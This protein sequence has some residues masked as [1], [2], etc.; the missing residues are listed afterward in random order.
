[1]G[2]ERGEEEGDCGSG[3]EY[4]PVSFHDFVGQIVLVFPLRS[5][6]GLYDNFR[7]HMVALNG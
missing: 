6:L 7:Y 5:L 2:E 1:M 4:K 3:E